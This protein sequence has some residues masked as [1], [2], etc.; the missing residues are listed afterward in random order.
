MR[1]IHLD[2]LKKW[3]RAKLTY[4]EKEFVTSI[5]WKNFECELCSTIYPSK[6]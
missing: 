3:I 2:C 6:F 1:Y 4:D 5:A